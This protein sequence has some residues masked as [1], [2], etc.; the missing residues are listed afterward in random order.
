MEIAQDL[1]AASN[2]L[3][4]D[5]CLAYHQQEEYVPLWQRAAAI[6]AKD[7]FPLHYPCHHYLVPALLLS[8][9][10]K[11]QGL[12]AEKLAA[13]LE[14]ARQRSSNVLGGFCGFY[15]TC[16]AAVGLG[17]FWSII[18]DTTPLSQISWGYANEATGQALLD[19]AALGGPR[20]C[21]RAVFL[22]LQS[23]LPQ[24]EARL[25]L[26]LELGEGLQCPFH[27][28]NKECIGLNCPFY[29]REEEAS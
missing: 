8:E 21:K 5:E 24:I 4:Y 26:K 20:C 2:R 6:M 12:P 22:T 17:I 9:C 10:R 13:D 18:T 19:I 3:I 29:P 27:E 15:G 11:R 14:T 23:A 1:L 7:G 28:R 16:G 25:G